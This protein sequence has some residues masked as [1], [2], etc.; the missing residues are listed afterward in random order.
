MAQEQ[1]RCGAPDPRL[2]GLAG[3]QNQHAAQAAD[4]SALLVLVVQPPKALFGHRSL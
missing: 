3:I 1:V 4:R 2:Q